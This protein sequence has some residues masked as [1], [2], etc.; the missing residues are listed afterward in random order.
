MS[1][2]KEEK[3]KLLIGR[4]ENIS[5]PE[6]G[7]VKI[8]ARVDTGAKTSSFWASNIREEDG[9]LSFT[10]FDKKSPLYTGKV[11]STTEFYRV[12]VASSIGEEQERYKVRLLIKLKGKKIR[13]RFTLANRSQQAYPVLLGRNV[14]RGKFIVDVT[15][16]KPLYQKE[17]ERSQKLQS[18]LTQL[19]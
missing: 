17:R 12:V 7:S 9:L 14:L 18:K 5:L 19:G 10:L 3:P 15:K 2:I 13:T 11:H 16:G 6:L 4:V 1:D 8:P